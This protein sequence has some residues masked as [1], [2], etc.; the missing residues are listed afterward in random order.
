MIHKR[1]GFIGAGQMATALGEGFVRAG[2][3]DPANLVASD[4]SQESCDRFA[5]ATGGR[6]GKCN[7]EATK[8]A[9]VLFLA[10]KPQHMAAVLAELKGKVAPDTLVI[11]I[12]AGT[13]LAT[14]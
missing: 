14:L 13:R 10:I 12:A 7:L 11:S 4:P 9:E 5:K 2:L 8:G 6:A 1:I 3:V